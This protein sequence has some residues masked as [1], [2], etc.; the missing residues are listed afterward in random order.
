MTMPLS[1]IDLAQARDAMAGLLD[2]IGLEAY[3]FDI[4]PKNGQWELKVECALEAREGWERIIVAVPG[5]I[6][7]ASRHDPAAHEHLAGLLREKLID[8]KLQ[9]PDRVEPGGS[10]ST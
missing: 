6:L 1:M 7:L 8:C 9:T 10:G 5:D 4:Q 3:L 2:E